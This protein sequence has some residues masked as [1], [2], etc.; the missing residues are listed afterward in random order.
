LRPSERDPNGPYGLISKRQI[1][2]GFDIFHFGSGKGRKI[3]LMIAALN[4]EK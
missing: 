1:N 4:F 3:D 2:T